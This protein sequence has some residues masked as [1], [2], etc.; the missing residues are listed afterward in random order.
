[1]PTRAPK[2][3]D[4]EKESDGLEKK[5]TAPVEVPQ[6]KPHT[7]TLLPPTGVRKDVPRSA[8]DVSSQTQSNRSP[9]RAST[10]AD[11]NQAKDVENKS[12]RKENADGSERKAD[13]EN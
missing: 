4:P 2:T 5:A 7:S 6:W 9:T 12:G 1:M 10:A 3:A 13:G 8:V 11:P